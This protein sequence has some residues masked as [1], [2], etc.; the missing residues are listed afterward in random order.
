MEFHFKYLK[1]ENWM[2]HT[3]DRDKSVIFLVREYFLHDGKSIYILY[4][5]PLDKKY[6]S[7]RLNHISGPIGIK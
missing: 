3:F 6:D 2:S 4:W 5:T 7:Y 1:S